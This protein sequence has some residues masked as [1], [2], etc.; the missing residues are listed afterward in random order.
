MCVCFS[1]AGAFNPANMQPQQKHSPLAQRSTVP[2]AASSVPGPRKRITFAEHDTT[3][4]ADSTS[5]GDDSSSVQRDSVSTQSSSVP[6]RMLYPHH[7]HPSVKMEK[8]SKLKHLAASL[9][10]WNYEGDLKGT[11]V[12]SRTTED[13][14][15][16]LRADGTILD[17]WTAEQIC[18]VVQNFGAR[19]M[20][21]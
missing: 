19:K 6:T 10:N 4:S 5:G 16:I 14:K 7:R 15:L 20:C 1:R 2:G 12:Y 3:Y 11:K 21:K 17:G 18:S 9:D 13:N 8:M